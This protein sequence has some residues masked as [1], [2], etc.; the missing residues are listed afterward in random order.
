M[1]E[2]ELGERNF[3][4]DSMKYMN[5]DLLAAT[6]CREAPPPRSINARQRAAR[7]SVFYRL[8]WK[9]KNQRRLRT[10]RNRL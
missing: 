6:G 1:V 10:R 8:M 7:G 4:F 5:C 9:W 3:G 2:K